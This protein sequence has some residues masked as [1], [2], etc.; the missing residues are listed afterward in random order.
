[1]GEEQQ[2]WPFLENQGLWG[3]SAEVTQTEEATLGVSEW[4][5]VEEEGWVIPRSQ[6]GGLQSDAESLK[7]GGGLP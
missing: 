3:H 7:L 4:F 1:M 6:T 2:N 5:Q